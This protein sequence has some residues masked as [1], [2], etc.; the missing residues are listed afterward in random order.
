MFFRDLYELGGTS[1]PEP[2]PTP[3][4]RSSEDWARFHNATFPALVESNLLA[5]PYP[6]DHGVLGF[7]AIGI[8]LGSP[9]VVPYATSVEEGM[10]NQAPVSG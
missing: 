7:K 8:S 6:R 1:L 10:I 9:Q 3:S 4:D 5:F 2:F